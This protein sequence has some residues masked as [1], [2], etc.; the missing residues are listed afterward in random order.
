MNITHRLWGSEKEGANSLIP[1]RFAEQ[2]L[3]CFEK[4]FVPAWN[5][6]KN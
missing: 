3:M 5:K 1:G 4:K 6:K 2:E